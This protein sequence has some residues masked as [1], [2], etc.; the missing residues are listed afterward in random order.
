MPDQNS[1]PPETLIPPSSDRSASVPDN[2]LFFGSEGLRAG[3][4]ILLFVL[5]FAGSAYLAA[6][7]HLFPR[8]PHASPGQPSPELYPA[9]SILSESLSLAFTLFATWIL[10]R[11]ERRPLSLYGLGR[12]HRLR[13]FLQGLFWGFTALSLLVLVLWQTHLL[14]FTGLLLAPAP[15]LR[16][17]LT[18]AF[19]FLIVALFEELFLRG[20]LQYTLTRGLEAVYRHVSSTHAPAL[21]FWSAALLLSA[22]FGFGHGSNP[23]ESPI[24]LF[25]AAVAG[26]VFT[27][28]LWRTG[29]LWWAIGM[30]TS[31]DWAQSFLY[32]VAD[33]GTLIR[34]HLLASHPQGRALFSGG[35]TGPEGSLF[36]LPTLALVAVGI[37]LTLP[38]TPRPTAHP[39]ESATEPATDLA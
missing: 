20:Y 29:S 36:V 12:Q 21:G 3:W 17:A 25:A 23:G 30:H 26:L 27:F 32:G 10:S 19:G 34:F 31:W 33:S 4:G 14:I 11:I 7:L 8:R 28:S 6:R 1:L 9:S 35:S 22:I 38:F 13:H 37:A 18:W 24:G 15:I 39:L 2:P 5:L 16:Y